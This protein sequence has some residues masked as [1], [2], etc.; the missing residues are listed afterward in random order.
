VGVVGLGPVSL[1]ELGVIPRPGQ[2]STVF[3]VLTILSIVLL[4]AS[5]VVAVMEPPWIDVDIVI[6]RSVVYGALS[7]AILLVYIAVAATVGVAAGVVVVIGTI[8]VATF[9]LR[10]IS[11]LFTEEASR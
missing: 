11:S 10:T 2:S 4:P 6:R 1:G 9:A 7:L 3:T 8:I 5:I